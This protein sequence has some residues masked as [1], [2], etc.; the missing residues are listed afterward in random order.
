M[1]T[2]A[3]RKAAPPK[4][5]SS[6]IAS[7]AVVDDELDSAQSQADENSQYTDDFEEESFWYQYIGS[8]FK[9]YVFQPFLIGASAAFGMSVGYALFDVV[10]KLFSKRPLLRG[11]V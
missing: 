2:I 3:N 7:G 11:A 5:A 4:G 10:S 6:N 8:D 9:K 1:T